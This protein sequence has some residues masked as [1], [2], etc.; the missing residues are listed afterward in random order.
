MRGALFAAMGVLAAIAS[1]SAQT[2]VT[3]KESGIRA[4]IRDQQTVISIPLQSVLEKATAGHLVLEWLRTDDQ[5]ISTVSRDIS[6]PP[7]PA[8]IDVPF[9]M[10]GSLTQSP[11]WLRL[12]YR[13][14]PDRSNV[15]TL[16][17]LS[18]IVALPQI[19]QHAFELA[20]MGSG[21]PRRGQPYS[22]R[23]HAFHPATGKGVPGVQFSA[24]LH[25]ARADIQPKR[26]TADATGFV[27][28]TFDLPEDMD[29]LSITTTARIGDFEQEEETDVSLEDRP[30]GRLQ[31]DKPIYQPGQV[32]HLRGLVFD[33][34]GQAAP[35][36]PVT[37]KIIDSQQET[38]HTAHLTSSRFGVIHDD[39]TIPPTA[40]L[41]NYQLELASEDGDSPLATHI[42]KISRYE[43]PAFSVS[44]KA[45]R[46]AYLPDQQA[47]VEVRG[48]YLFGKPVPKGKVRI[49]R[50]SLASWNPRKR[51]A[52]SEEEQVQEGQADESGLFTAHLNL[53]AGHAR[54]K[55]DQHVRFEDLHYAVYYTDPGSGRTAQKRFDLR[56][57]R[58]PIHIYVIRSRQ[59]GGRLPLPVYISTSYATGTPAQATAEISFGEQ[60]A[61]VRTNRFG[62]GRVMLV[63]Q[64]D[65]IRLRASDASGLI[66]NWEEH[67]NFW[68]ED[69]I[70]VQSE[71]SIYR[72]GE[73]VRVHVTA[74]EPGADL[75]VN[76]VRGKT[77]LASRVAHLANGQAEVVF[78]YQSDF[79]HEIIF[80]A[81]S[82]ISGHHGS[83][84]V[85]F[86]DA[87]GL[88]LSVAP[89]KKTYRP[90]QDAAVLMNLNAADGHPVSGVLGVAV[91]DQAVMEQARTGEEFGRRRWF[92]CAFCADPDWSQLGSVTLHDLYNLDPSKPLA[93]GL[94]LV[95]EALLANHQPELE[96]EA[97]SEYHDNQLQT[98]SAYFK[99]QFERVREILDDSYLITL[100]YPRD[101][102]GVARLLSRLGMALESLRD[103][104]DSQY[105]VRSRIEHRNDVLEFV[106]PGPDKQPGTADDFVAHHVSRPYFLPYERMITNALSE[107]SIPASPEQLLKLLNDRGVRPETLRDPWGTL[108][109]VHVTTWGAYR[110]IMILSAGPDRIFGT[111]DDFEISQFMKP[112][113][114]QEARSI[115]QILNSAPEFPRT[116]EQLRNT[117]IS[118]GFDVAKLID[119]W[120]RPYTVDIQIASRYTDRSRLSTVRIYNE[121]PQTKKDIVPVT[122]QVVSI[123]L[124]SVGEDGQQGTGDDFTVATFTKVISEQT[125]AS[126]V[127]AS[128]PVGGTPGAGS[129]IITGTVTNPSG[130]TIPKAR[131]MLWL[132]ISRSGSP[133]QYATTDESGTYEFRRLA[134]GFYVVVCESPGFQRTTVVE[135]PVTDGH[136]TIVD[137]VLQVGSVSEAVEV[138][139]DL[140]LMLQTSSGMV[141]VTEVSTPRVRE[142]FPETLF[143]APEV[144]TGQQGH[145]RVMFKLA[146]SITT[147]KLAVIASTLDG[148]VTEAEA[149][150]QAF[151]PFFVDHNP[152]PVLT[153]GDEVDLPVTVRNYLNRAQNV[154]V[155]MQANDWS[156]LRGPAKQQVNV[157]PNASVNVVYPLRAKTMVES[158]R[159]RVTAVAAKVSDAIEKK[160]NVHPDG[161]EVAQT[162]GDIIIG[163]SSLAIAIPADAIPGATRG[164][165][166]VYPS[167]LSALL[168]GNEGILQRPYG[169]GEQTTSAG[170]TN[171]IALRYA[172]A[173][174]IKDAK[175]EKRAIQNLEIARD[176]LVSYFDP[177]GGV[178]YWQGGDAD[179][180][181]TAHALSFLIAAAEFMPVEPDHLHELSSW[182]VKQQ[183]ADGTWLRPAMTNE[184][185]RRRSLLVTAFTVR[186]LAS[187][188]K[189]RIQVP[190]AVFSRAYHQLATATDATAEPYMVALFTLAAL[191]SG[192][193][194]L[195]R[196]SAA[197]LEESAR[198]ERD[199]VYWDL[200]T[201]TPFYGWGTAGRVET[202]ALA[203]AAL[204]AW[205]KAHP[206]DAR[207]DSL[208]RRGLLFLVRHR[209]RYGVW[210]STQATVRAM[211]A[212]VA[213][214]D[215]L[216]SL[217]GQGASVEVRVNG[218]LAATVKSAG[219]RATDPVLVDVSSLLAPGD[220]QVEFVP[221][222]SS[223][224]AV[225]RLVA[226]HWIP[227]T[228]S[229]PPAS[230]ELRLSVT[231]DRTNARAGETIHCQVRAERI[232]FRGYGMMLAEIGLPP[233]SEVDRGT[234]ERLVEDYSLGVTQFDVLPDR[235]VLYLWPKAG[236]SSFQF[237]FRP[238]FAMR[239]KS[240]P[241]LLYDY[242]NPEAA[243]RA[244]PALFR[245]EPPT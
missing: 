163:R 223:S 2:L 227:W 155:E 138:V 31:T 104:W 43:L 95:A 72:R 199:G 202:S 148:R 15:R 228:T 14:D 67:L 207:L 71:R 97:A 174:G 10:P 9:P 61:T 88:S 236:G 45:D 54:L 134:A 91:V 242:Y 50:T 188:S 98:Y 6:V 73:P 35:S 122:Q 129:G 214:S 238:R 186:A 1:A 102:V 185:Q 160:L 239:A 107:E 112:Y 58:E 36:V 244:A 133:L 184:E 59:A 158:G 212:V 82:D 130:A 68:R 127:V 166:R 37:L 205:R 123:S 218:R 63:P 135:I 39:W 170:Y 176:R 19:A 74:Q 25:S 86:P 83:K 231:F 115:S 191:A 200:R 180:S 206:E 178:R 89:E 100:D 103:P 80:V 159:Q 101:Q 226:T 137:T 46:E 140:P 150:L 44:A 49:V 5:V 40:S 167:L 131:V 144:E 201:N 241:S 149:D 75:V 57:T 142:Y 92:V 124:R 126:Q 141:S 171:L 94:D 203:V 193:R 224:P 18:G 105:V 90:G 173:L 168:E 136:T 229:S 194:E 118:G 219:P 96:I 4:V 221:S 8:T 111:K 121:P 113:F 235:V 147:W 153:T 114:Q 21:E 161:E 132:G 152:P 222:A 64:D 48:A 211:E 216:G 12:R 233:G 157:E 55:E 217:G 145:A 117:L 13:L 3:I 66:G 11:I 169:C 245:V 109:R 220:N 172:R 182:L 56:I 120:G 189:N 26:K 87:S 42:V 53:D 183:Q 119:A 47:A 77:V 232:G 116:E 208:I 84:A 32:L 93:D 16:H 240:A 29:D 60:Q 237:D 85:I 70:R 125:A 27:I 198:P 78:P 99:T 62:V 7:G 190:P 165:V 197:K 164:E 79:E 181:L 28:F 24:V 230:D 34:A 51:T 143:W 52:E 192:D 156:E 38:A 41:G 204:S 65:V 162:V 175:L 69:S 76:A 81:Y 139:G 210:Y 146:D 179:I 213:A 243:A 154:S 215:V 33:A 234:L 108:Y 225:V 209:D 110:T 23:A 22:V 20:V 106:S 187:A 151:Q 17:P 177:R 196:S 128:P 195:A 30:A